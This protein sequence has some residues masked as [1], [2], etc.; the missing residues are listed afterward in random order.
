MSEAFIMHIDMDAFFASIE[1][2]DHP[3]WKGKPVIVGGGD[4][5]VV[6]TAS[7]EARRFGIHSAMPAWQA[8]RRCPGGIFVTPNMIRYKEISQAI[9][10]CLND[11][12]PLVEMASVD[13]AYLDLTGIADRYGSI[14]KA[15]GFIKH[16]VKSATGGLSCS[17]GVAPLKFLAK[18]CSEEKKPDGLFILRQSDMQSF[19]S[20]LD[21][22]R[23]PGVGRKFSAKLNELGITKGRQVLALQREFWERRFGKIGILLY[24]RISG[25]DPSVVIPCRSPKSE[26][27]ECTLPADTDDKEVLRSWLLRHAERV[28]RRIRKQGLRGK[29][30]TLKIKYA[31]FTGFTKQTTLDSATDST[32]TLFSTGCALL[33]SAILTQKIRLI[34][35]G[36]SNFDCEKPR[37]ISL[38]EDH[39]MESKETQNRNLDRTLDS[40]RSKYG[41]DIICRGRLFGKNNGE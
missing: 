12:S 6:S 37:R 38:L 2:M 25:T 15:A 17:I 41:A 19:L 27:A 9:H 24:D 40:L 8:R 4:R 36:I 23:I 39:S 16:S 7:Y 31:D 1:Q 3:E 29:T 35:L 10:E 28:G 21:V 26:S 18:I 11:V 20:D 30:I 34:G 22:C 13:E 32:V 5:G 14:E 33:D